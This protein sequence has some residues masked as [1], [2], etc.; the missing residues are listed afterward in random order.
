MIMTM[1]AKS[2]LKTTTITTTAACLHNR[3]LQI[4]NITLCLWR[5]RHFCWKFVTKAIAFPMDRI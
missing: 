4:A 2:A 5:A 1:T 3:S